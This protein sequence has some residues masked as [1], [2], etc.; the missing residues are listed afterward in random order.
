MVSEAKPDL[1]TYF[2]MVPEG[3]LGHKRV[4]WK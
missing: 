1:M 3:P 2:L 4:K